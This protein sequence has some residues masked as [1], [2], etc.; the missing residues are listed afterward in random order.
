MKV[1]IE[2]KVWDV[3]NI[4]ADGS[5]IVAILKGGRE[6]VTRGANAAILT[7]AFPKALEAKKPA[8]K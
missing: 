6:I 5:K 8:S 7:A 1:T 3:E 2:S 4:R